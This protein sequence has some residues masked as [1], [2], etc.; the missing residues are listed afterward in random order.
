MPRRSVISLLP[1]AIKRQL[2]A[3]LRDS[4]FGDLVGIAAW[5]KR[6]GH[7]VGKSAVGAYA[8]KFRAV[9]EVGAPVQ[10]AAKATS[11]AAARAAAI[12]L[13]CL[14]V[15]AQTGPAAGLLRRAEVYAQWVLNPVK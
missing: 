14:H 1:P 10:P 15:A 8:L 4:A 9:I 11:P 6:R 7:P 12:R 13:G 2:D 3:R 5:L